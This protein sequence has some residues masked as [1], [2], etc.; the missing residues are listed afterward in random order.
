[1]IASLSEATLKQYAGPLE[2]WRL[3]CETK[4]YNFL[5]I[6]PQVLIEFLTEQYDKGASYGTI[7]NYRSA[8]SLLS[9]EKIGS[10]LDVCRFMK[11]IWRNRPQLPKYNNTWDVTI[12]LNYL[13]NLDVSKLKN[14]A[15]K[16]VTLLALCS[17]QRAQTLS[18]VKL[19]N[20]KKVPDGLE[21]KI[22]DLLKTSGPGRAQ[23]VLQLSLFKEKPQLCVVTSILEYITKTKHIRKNVDELFLSTVKPF[24]AISST[25]ISKWVKKILKQSGIDVS[26]FT[27]HS[28]RHASTSTAAENE[29]DF[30]TIRRTAGWSESSQVFA[31][32]YKRP[33][34]KNGFDFT[35]VVLERSLDK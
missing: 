27:A 11:G 8:V 1:M 19:S 21:I 26:T 14:L 12:V 25:T 6:T 35:K 2:Q 15:F 23:P 7:N 17:A 18:K 31:K 3:F 30:D 33:I 29:I 32:H 22:P 34:L 16:T 24:H 20:I 13:E 28:T 9:K 4:N 5:D 10:H